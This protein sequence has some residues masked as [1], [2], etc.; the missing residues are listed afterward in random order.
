MTAV[1]TTE[2]PVGRRHAYQV[3]RR[4]RTAGRVL[5]SDRRQVEEA[6]D[7][8]T[9]GAQAAATVKVTRVVVLRIVG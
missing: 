6:D 8:T 9:G 2:R 3:G 1:A 7:D 5:V 4:R